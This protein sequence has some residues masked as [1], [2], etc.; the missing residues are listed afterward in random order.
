MVAIHLYFSLIGLG[1]FLFSDE[2]IRPG[3]VLNPT[4]KRQYEMEKKRQIDAKKPKSRQQQQKEQLEK[5]LSTAISSDNKG[6]Q[7]LAKMG[8]KEGEGLG[9]AKTGRTEPIKIEL[10][11]EKL[12]L[13]VETHTKDVIKARITKKRENLAKTVSDFRINNKL[14]QAQRYL[15]KDLITAQRACEDLDIKHNMESPNK[16]FFWTR[17]TMKR[18]K[19]FESEEDEI[20]FDDEFSLFFTDDNLCE[21][22][23]YLR[24]TYLYCIYCAFVA[25]DHDDLNTNC[26]GIH[27]N[28]HDDA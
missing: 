1:N 14:K 28:D 26:P 8:F 16:E 5:G 3:L 27:R 7:M 24:D 10:K 4:R 19:N 23:Q 20:E 25:S 15:H 21:I 2:D 12:G 13:G 9:K 17:D 11:T 6:F 22:I 18:K